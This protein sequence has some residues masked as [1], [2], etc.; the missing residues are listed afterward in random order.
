MPAVLH[1]TETVITGGL[2]SREHESQEEVRVSSGAILTPT[3]WDYLRDRGLR[4][5][6]TD[7]VEDTSTVKPSGSIEIPEVKT[8]AMDDTS[9]VQRGRCDHPDQ[10]YGCKTDEFGSGFV[11]PDSSEEPD[12][13]PEGVENGFE[14]DRRTCSTPPPGPSL[15]GDLEIEA[16]IQRITDE[17]LARLE[18]M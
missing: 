14:Q 4:L 8:D 11:Q 5:T 10:A 18:E 13:S 7:E 12:V 3:A 15:A 1:I 6:R 9:L 17:V 16:L 2:L